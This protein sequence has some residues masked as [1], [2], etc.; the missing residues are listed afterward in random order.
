MYIQ[1]GKGEKVDVVLFAYLTDFYRVWSSDK[2]WVVVVDV[3][4][5]YLNL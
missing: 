4:G 2:L 5:S 3:Y 1:S